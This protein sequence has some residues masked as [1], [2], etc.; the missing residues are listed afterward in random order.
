MLLSGMYKYFVDVVVFIDCVMG[1]IFLVENNIV[2]EK[3]YLKVCKNVGELVFLI[4]NGYF[5]I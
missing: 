3:G 5:D 1:K 4:F 2:L